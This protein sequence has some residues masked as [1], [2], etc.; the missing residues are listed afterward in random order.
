MWLPFITLKKSGS[1]CLP[2]NEKNYFDR[3]SVLFE[4]LKLASH[5]FFFSRKMTDRF[6][7]VSCS[8]DFFT[9]F[10]FS[11]T[12]VTTHFMIQRVVAFF[13]SFMKWETGWF[14]EQVVDVAFWNP[15]I[16]LL[17]YSL[18]HFISQHLLEC[19]L[20]AGHLLLVG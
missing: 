9:H 5:P 10:P 19:L 7:F 13:R 14:I 18:K 1:L 4:S 16:S 3:Y 8:S 17:Q 12:T 6:T 20:I 11:C 15:N 2:W